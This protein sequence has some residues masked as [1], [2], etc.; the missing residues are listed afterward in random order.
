MNHADLY[1]QANEQ[2]LLK[3]LLPIDK[4]YYD[5]LDK[6]YWNEAYQR[7]SFLEWQE[8]LA[9]NGYDTNRIKRNVNRNS[10]RQFFYEGEYLTPEIN[11]LDPS[12]LLNPFTI[13]CLRADEAGKREF[14]NRNYIMYFFSENN[15]FAI[16][17]FIRHFDKIDEED[18]YSAFKG[19]YVYCNYGFE[20][21]P[22][23]L[24]DKVFAKADNEEGVNELETAGVADEDGYLTIY[25]GEGMRSTPIEKA[26]SWT[27]SHETAHRFGHFY[28]GGTVYQAR[29][30]IEDIIDFISERDE[31]EVWVRYSDIEDIQII[32]TG[33]AQ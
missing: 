21:F 10:I 23:E 20:M 18:V 6:T 32:S 19:L 26:H 2:L 13:S 17:Y 4:E 8:V 16:D 15:L 31:E 14:E 22:T 27:L 25:R 1:F 3:N 11:A 28:Q 5:S 29:V 9:Q 30:K 7:F 33:Q 24:L 12:W